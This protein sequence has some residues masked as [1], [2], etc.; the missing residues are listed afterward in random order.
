MKD[1]APLRESPF[2]G[3]TGIA[4][5]INA[6]GY[7]FDGLRAAFR[8]EDAFRQLVL[9]SAVLIPLAF[10]VH[11]APL[12]RALLIAS[13]LATLIIE[14]LNSAI[15]A[16]V[17]HTSLER[18]PLAKRAKDMGSAAQLLGLINLAVVW[19]VVLFG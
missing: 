5:L 19:G 4:R 6:L 16:A 2:K 18:H 10:F 9:L 17:D 1:G 12:A 13:S 8:H 11:A 3:K 7:S 14:L 15:E